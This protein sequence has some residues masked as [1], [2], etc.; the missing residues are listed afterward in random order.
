MKS[1]SII[2]M[3]Y[4]F[5]KHQGEKGQKTRLITVLTLVETVTGMSNAVIVD[6][7]GVTQYALGEVKKFILEKGFIKSVIQVDGE[8]AIKGVAEAIITSLNGEVKSRLSPAYPHQSLGACE[9]WH[10]KLF[11]HC[12][13]L[14]LQMS[15]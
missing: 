1:K 3:Y 13:L 14:R 8:Q 10:T 9:G 2:Q 7:K 11:N 5:L 15:E 4:T 6:Y 12:R